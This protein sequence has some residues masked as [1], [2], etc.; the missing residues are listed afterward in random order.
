M[1]NHFKQQFNKPCPT[2]ISFFTCPLH[3]DKLSALF[4]KD[5]NPWLPQPLQIFIDFNFHTYNCRHT[6]WST[7]DSGVLYLITLNKACIWMK[8]PS[9]EDNTKLKE[10]CE[11][12][13]VGVWQWQAASNGQAKLWKNDFH[14]SPCSCDNS[15]HSWPMIVFTFPLLR[16]T[17]QHFWDVVVDWLWHGAAMV[18]SNDMETNNGRS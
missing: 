7:G 17:I 3:F 8:N 4:N 12:R 15:S 18:V 2:L 13:D 5:Y 14:K 1:P 16:W 11:D 6:N 9:G 10:S